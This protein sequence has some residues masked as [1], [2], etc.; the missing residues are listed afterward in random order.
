MSRIS[1][2]RLNR[3]I[4]SVEAIAES[5]LGALAAAGVLI[6]IIWRTCK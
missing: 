4:D 3:F 5:K 2:H 1:L 6:V